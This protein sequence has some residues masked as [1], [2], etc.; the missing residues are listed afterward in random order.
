MY[1]FTSNGSCIARAL[2]M[3]TWAYKANFLS[4]HFQGP[5][6]VLRLGRSHGFK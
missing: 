5:T 3:Y 2:E 4:S 6:F 1:I